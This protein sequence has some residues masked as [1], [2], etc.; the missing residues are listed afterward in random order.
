MSTP[1]SELA[2]QWLDSDLFHDHFALALAALGKA[3]DGVANG[4]AR[5]DGH[6]VGL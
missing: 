5:P 2:Y 3:Q 4:A 1:S 6:K